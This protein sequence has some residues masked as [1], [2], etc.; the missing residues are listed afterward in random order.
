[1]WNKASLREDLKMEVGQI[2]SDHLES[3]GMIRGHGR[4]KGQILGL[5]EVIADHLKSSR[6]I[7][8]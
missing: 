5:F 7:W 8:G 2:F 1:M 3:S 4:S 6:I